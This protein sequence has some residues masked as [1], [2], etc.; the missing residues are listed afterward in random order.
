[1]D[2]RFR[3]PAPVFALVLASM[4]RKYNRPFRRDRAARSRS[5]EV[6]VERRGEARPHLREATIPQ[7]H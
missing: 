7:F 3:L 1:M 4:D 2:V 5:A 6:E